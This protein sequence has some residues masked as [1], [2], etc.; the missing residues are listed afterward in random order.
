MVVLGLEYHGTEY[1]GWQKQKNALAIQVV[2][3]S[4]LSIVA[5]RPIATVCAGRTDSGVHALGQVV[6]FACEHAR[7]AR[8]WIRGGNSNLPA[9]VRVVWMRQADEQFS[10]RFSA[11]QR[12]YRYLIYNRQVAPAILTH[13]VVHQPRALDVPA[14]RRA[15][16][17]LVGT[18]DYTS[19]RAT[20][21]QASSPV[22][23]VSRLEVT[24]SGDLV[25][26]DISANAFLHHMVRNIAGVLMMIGT[27]EQPEAWA[28]E[29][30][31]A[32]DRRRGGMTAPPH[33]LYL[34]GVDYPSW[35]VDEVPNSSVDLN[36]FWSQVDPG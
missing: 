9:D 13:R 25:V 29:V 3:E 23:T 5:D 1:A 17:A 7:S 28:A 19:Y 32:R 35:G 24:R 26:I 14:M 34:V 21:C 15:A 22:R 6:S 11:L 27:G 12:H 33:G 31:A 10:A 20:A 16:D 36:E 2:V 4:A 18:H 30:L 8:A